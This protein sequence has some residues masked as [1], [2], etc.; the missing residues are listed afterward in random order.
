MALQSEINMAPFIRIGI[1]QPDSQWVTHVHLVKK[2]WHVYLQCMVMVWIDND[3]RVGN[4]IRRDANG[5]GS[6]WNLE[7]SRSGSNFS[8]RS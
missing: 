7:F 5:L 2:G 4:V 8:I 3:G 6:E 1:I